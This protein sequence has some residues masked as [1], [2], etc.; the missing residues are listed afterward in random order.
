LVY[1][2]KKKTECVGTLHANRT[3]S[4]PVVKNKNLKKAEYCGQHSGD[5][6]VL[7]SQD[8]KQVIMIS[9]YHKS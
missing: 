6:A 8:K 1:E 2:G 4:P 3:D 5:V 7:V 9:A